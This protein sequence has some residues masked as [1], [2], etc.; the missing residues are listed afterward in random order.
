MD[1]GDEKYVGTGIIRLKAEQKSMHVEL[2]GR[3][4]ESGRTNDFQV[5]LPKTKE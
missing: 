3:K 2:F 4:S 1:F 5:R